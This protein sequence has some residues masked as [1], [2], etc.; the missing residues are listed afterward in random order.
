MVTIIKSILIDCPLE[1]VFMFVSKYKNDTIWRKD[2]IEMLQFP[3]Y[4]TFVGTTTIETIKIFGIKHFVSAEVYE[5]ERN[6]KVSFRTTDAPFTVNG[7]RDV[8]REKDKTKFTYA[9]NAELK[10]IYKMF[11]GFIVYHLRKRISNDLVRLKQILEEK[12]N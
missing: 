11:A 3:D 12:K 1:E 4:S 8:R 9:L 6:K 2:V 7:Y 10:G 5:Y